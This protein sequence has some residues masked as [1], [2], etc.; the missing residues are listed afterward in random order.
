MSIHHGTVG[1]RQGPGPRALGAVPSLGRRQY[2]Q[3][4]PGSTI[5]GAQAVPWGIGHVAQAVPRPEVVTYL[6]LNYNYRLAQAVQ[7]G[8][9]VALIDYDPTPS[10]VM[11]PG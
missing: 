6:H 3:W 2:H 8:S 10:P 7:E 4:G 1:Q 11:Y 9:P 5:N